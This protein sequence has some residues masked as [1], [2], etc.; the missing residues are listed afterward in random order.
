MIFVEFFPF[1]VNLEV[2]GRVNKDDKEHLVFLWFREAQ[3][4]NGLGS[5]DDG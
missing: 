2:A 1:C 4:L 3:F 5:Q